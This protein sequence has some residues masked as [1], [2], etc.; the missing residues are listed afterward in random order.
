MVEK[1][2]RRRTGNREAHGDNLHGGPRPIL[3]G[4]D[5]TVVACF[6]ALFQG[7]HLGVEFATQSNLLLAHHGL[8]LPG[9]QFLA[10]APLEDDRAVIGLVIDDF[11]CRSR[12]PVFDWNVEEF[13]ACKKF[14]LAKQV[15]E[16]EDILGS[17]KDVH[18]Q[19]RFKVIGAGKEAWTWT[20]QPPFSR[21]ALHVRCLALNV[22]WLMDFGF[23]FP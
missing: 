15:Y 7:D 17:D 1:F 20:L 8:L 4:P 16:N 14:R 2:G 13:E 22:G 23:G 12:E 19:T 21:A 10:D 9:S 3:F 5:S 18:E 6:G 11:F